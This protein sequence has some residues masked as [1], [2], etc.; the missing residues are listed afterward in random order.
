MKR[1][2][3]SL[4]VAASAAGVA[5]VSTAQMY[6]NS[7]G[8][9][10]ALV[11]PFYSA[12]NGNDTS[13][14]IVNTTADFKA[15]KVRMLE[16]TESLETLSFNLYMSPQ[17][18]FSFAITADGEGAKLITNDTSCTVPAITGPVSFT[19]LMWADEA[20]TSESR[21]QMGHVE[22]IEMGQIDA[23]SATAGD[24]E[25][26]SG[27]P[28]DCAQLV[29]NWS[30]VSD[31]EG[32]WYSE[33]DAGDEDPGVGTTDFNAAWNGG[34]LY[35]VA[36]VINVAEGGQFGYNA[37]AIEDLVDASSTGSQLHYPPHVGGPDFDD[38][39]MSLTANISL[40]GV[41]TTYTGSIASPADAVS[42][43]FMT[44]S[45]SNDFLSDSSL[46]TLTDWV[47]TMP[48]KDNTIP[49]SSDACQPVAMLAFDREE[50][51]QDTSAADSLSL[52]AGTNVV[53]FGG[54]SATN[55]ASNLASAQ[56]YVDSMADGWAELDL[57]NGEDSDRVL[58]G[59]VSGSDEL[60]AGLPV[61]GFAVS[62]L[63]IGSL[64]GVLA[65]Y[66]QSWSHKTSV[67]TSSSD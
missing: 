13:I 43:L 3:L 41:Q 31:V 14:H 48:T 66:Q 65:N 64:G 9:G 8:T 12:Q 35:G 16:G 34:G 38:A 21:E 67:V 29:T 42:A 7:E 6:I 23:D 59:A 19:D 39:A 24:I 27:T 53:H 33:A 20:G 4:A 10:E 45:L 11:F 15:V 54:A 60:L 52:C 32:A 1:N 56:S 61:T 47:I 17:D 40:G 50:G 62:E 51:T 55:S 30:V 5:G 22:V 49:F 58:P 46:G 26:V 25:H 2:L 63:S 44:A 36:S 37:V 18:H 28:A 57:T